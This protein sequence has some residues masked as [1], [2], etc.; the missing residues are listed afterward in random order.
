MKHIYLFLPVIIFSC[1][2]KSAEVATDAATHDTSRLKAV[3][4]GFDDN[5]FESFLTLDNY[6]PDETPPDHNLQVIESACAVMINPTDEQIR[7]MEKIHGDDFDTILDDA[8]FYQT[9]AAIKLDSSKIRTIYAA[10]RF[11]QFRGSTGTWTLDIRKEG[12][13]EWNFILF[14]EGRKPEIIAAVD[15]T[16]EKIDEYF[17][18]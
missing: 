8:S 2:A 16:Y 1:T 5:N 15:I 6:T 17:G 13:P 4:A 7:Q 18:N 10:Q 3:Y 9:E 11:L 12:A 14:Q